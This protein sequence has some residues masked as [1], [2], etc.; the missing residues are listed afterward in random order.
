MDDATVHRF[1]ELNLQ[2][3]DEAAGARENSINTRA[4]RS[5][6]A[7]P[8][9]S[10]SFPGLL[11]EDIWKGVCIVC[12]EKHHLSNVLRA[13]CGHFHC[14]EC[15]HRR[16]EMSTRDESLF[17]PSCCK[18]EIPLPSSSKFLGNELLELLKSKA[19]EYETADRVYCNDVFCSTFISSEQIKHG[20]AACPRCHKETCAMCKGPQ[21]IHADCPEDPA[22][23]E[24][25]ALAKAEKW[26]RCLNCKRRVERETGCN[27]MTYGII[28]FPFLGSR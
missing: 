11:T 8:G 26:A 7:P 2:D 18:Q 22:E 28:L 27:H 3:V 17:P 21:H 19:K 1:R 16:A 24:L 25:E 5:A 4:L 6:S 23:R 14:Q 15:F 20:V 12:R 13:P 9:P 10:S